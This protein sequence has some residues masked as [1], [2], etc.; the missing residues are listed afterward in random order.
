MAID[1]AALL[2]KRGVPFEW[3]ILG[4]GALR[5]ALQKQINACGVADAVHLLGVRANPY[6]YIKHAQL[7]VQ[8]SRFEGKSIVVDEAKILCTPVL[9]T[10]YSTARDQITDGQNGWIA[11][12]NAEA[13]AENISR[14]MAAPEQLQAVRR[15]QAAEGRGNTAEVEKYKKLFNA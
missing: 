13:L 14:L 4:Q 3:F 7:L 12:M 15:A 10:E 9:L 1:A 11:A 2:K 8:S 5:N 6:P